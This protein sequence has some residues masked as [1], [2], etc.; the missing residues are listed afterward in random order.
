MNAQRLLPALLVLAAGCAEDLTPASLLV[1]SRA[2][3][4]KV[5]VTTDPTRSNPAPGETADV[6]ILYGDPGAEPPRTWF[7]LVCEPLP[8]TYG[9]P[10]C[11]SLDPGD[12][13]AAPA[14]QTALAT[15]RPFDPPRISFTVP[16]ADQ[17]SEGTT[18]LLM[19][20]AICSGGIVDPPA[21][22]Q[23]FADLAAGTARGAP[24]VCADG[25]GDGELVTLR[26]PLLLDGQTNTHPSIAAIRLDGA[27]WTA[28]APE[29]APATGCV[30]LG[31]AVPTVPGSSR[32]L[33]LE[34]EVAPGSA[35]TFTETDATGAVR[36]VTES[37]Q[38]SYTATA[39]ETS[40]YFG[41]IDPGE[42]TVI[43]AVSWDLPAASSV[44]ADG[45]LVRFFF[46]LRDGRGGVDYAERAI[47]LVP[48]PA[49]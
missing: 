49:G 40:K 38:I 36:E 21:I 44:P 7:L 39:G 5:T 42:M 14:P 16:A 13:I 31:A 18:E 33:E 32:T 30:S 1:R 46:P 20:G 29:D 19:L 6:E 41:F 10:M 23:Y 43:D 2:L 3:A 28:V 8:T 26:L 25:I 35:E 12:W 4:A 15:T 37:L 22:G 45:L 47:C 48:D 11:A 27:P 24:P 17:L 34:L 9:T